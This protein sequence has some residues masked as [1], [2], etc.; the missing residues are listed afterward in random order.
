MASSPGALDWDR[1]GR[2]WPNREASRFVEAGGLRWHV[3]QFGEGPSALL[4][5]GTG[6]ST[7]SWARLTP[8]LQGRLSLLAMDLPSHAFTSAVPT[9]RMSLPSVSEAVA[10]LLTALDFEP[11]L[12][13]GH[14]AGAAIL[15]RMALDGR[16]APR[17]IASINGALSPFPGIAA[18]IFPAMA[19]MLFLNPLTPR[20]F[21]WRAAQ[22]GAV[23]KLIEG[24]GSHIPPESLA[25]YR[26]L[27]SS[28]THVAGALAMMANWDLDRLMLDLPHLGPHLLQIVGSIDLAIPPERSF[29]VARRVPGSAVEL[30]RGAGHLA[31]E[32]NPESVAE[33]I[34][35]AAAKFDMVDG[36]S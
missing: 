29:E 1:D 3:Q 20:V 7:H 9:A 16:I 19:K 21:A 36:P 17:M 11:K 33:A 35:R 5:H 8:Y 13:I 26:R 23:E 34:L 10:A 15:A 28:P 31:H 32:E 12:A 4:I 18:H 14:S 2:D 24:T 22:A 27:F 6:A 30:V 25:L